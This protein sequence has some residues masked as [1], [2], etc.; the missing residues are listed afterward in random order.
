MC[1]VYTTFNN[2]KTQKNSSVDM[3][4][5]Y[6]SIIQSLFPRANI[7]LYCFH[8]VQTINHAINRYWIKNMN[9]FR[10]LDKTKYNS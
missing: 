3:Y 7:I 10:S 4:L 5:H 8:I 1:N 6:M 9:N 2:N